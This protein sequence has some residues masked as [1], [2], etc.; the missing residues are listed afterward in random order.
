MLQGMAGAADSD[1]DGIITINEL[2]SYLQHQVAERARQQNERQSPS[3]AG[4]IG[5]LPFVLIQK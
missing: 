2:F 1:R 3:M 4:S 5:D